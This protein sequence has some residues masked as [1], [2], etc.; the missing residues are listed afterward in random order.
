M[1]ATFALI[2]LIMVDVSTGQHFV[3]YVKT[4][5]FYLTITDEVT[6]L[7]T[8]EAAS[9]GAF[10]S[11]WPLVLT[12]LRLWALPRV[13]ALRAVV[14]LLSTGALL[15]LTALCGL[16]PLAKPGARP[17]A[18]HVHYSDSGSFIITH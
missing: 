2:T 5:A 17:I 7:P 3:A 12:A 15:G 6:P 10:F 11:A 14:R 16:M 4:S 8:S 18:L 13:A 1:L 9:T